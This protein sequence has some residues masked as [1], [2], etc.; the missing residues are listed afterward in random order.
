MIDSLKTFLHNQFILKDLDKLKHFLSLERARTHNGIFFS[1]IN[2]TLLLLEDTGFL[3]CIPATLPM[4][5]KARLGSFEG[6]LLDDTSLCRRLVGRLLYL[7]ISPP[8]ITFAVYKLS[9]FVSQPRQPHLD[10]VHRLLQ[11]VKATPGQ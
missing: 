11:Y 5:P 7:T 6:E 9:Q 1:Q 3:G 2:Y 10:A 8:D 4:D